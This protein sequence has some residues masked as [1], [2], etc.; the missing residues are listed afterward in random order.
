M[1]NFKNAI[2]A[3]RNGFDY[4]ME[5]NTDGIEEKLKG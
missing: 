3:K 1:D 4:G 2:E 5:V